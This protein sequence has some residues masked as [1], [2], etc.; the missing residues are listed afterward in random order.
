MTDIS[1][2]LQS[3]ELLQIS[4]SGLFTGSNPSCSLLCVLL[5]IPPACTILIWASESALGGVGP[6]LWRWQRDFLVSFLPLQYLK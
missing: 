4:V 5:S 6:S 1:A 3:C 2:Y